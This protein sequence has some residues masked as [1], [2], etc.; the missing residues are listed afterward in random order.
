[1]PGP[2]WAID[3]CCGCG[4]CREVRVKVMFCGYFGTKGLLFLKGEAGWSRYCRKEVTMWNEGDTTPY[5]TSILERNSWSGELIESTE[6]GTNDF[7]WYG[8]WTITT[9]TDDTLIRETSLGLAV[10]KYQKTQLKQKNTPTAAIAEAQQYLQEADWPEWGKTKILLNPTHWW[11]DT[12]SQWNNYAYFAIGS[13]YI[14]CPSIIQNLQWVLPSLRN[15]TGDANRTG[16]YGTDLENAETCR[17]SKLGAAA[18]FQ[19]EWAT[20]P[21]GVYLSDDPLNPNGSGFIVAETSFCIMS[22]QV[23]NIGREFSVAVIDNMTVVNTTT[24]LFTELDRSHYFEAQEVTEFT[25]QPP[26]IPDGCPGVSGSS[27]GRSALL[28]LE[29]APLRASSTTVKASS[30]VRVDFK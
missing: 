28:Y 13:P 11:N 4:G 12:A 5:Y 18:S 23:Q 1:M 17:I 29:N 7:S 6:S 20:Q 10:K 25:L 15:E 19:F 9:W 3:N 30:P 16:I 8:G 27:H 24:P 22:T 2:T 21:P 26:P 14:N